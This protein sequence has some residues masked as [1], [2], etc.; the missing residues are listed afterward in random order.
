M[1][2]LLLFTVLSTAAVAG[3][4]AD[5]HLLAGARRFREGRFAE[6]L[7]EFRVAQ[8]LGHGGEAGWYSAACLV[9]L[10]RP[11]DALEAFAEAE[12]RSP[13]T[14]DELFDYY[15]AIACHDARLYLCADRLLRGVGDRAGPRIR[16]EARRLR[17]EVAAIL[18]P[19]PARTAIDWYQK[20]ARQAAQGGRPLIAKAYSDEAA[21]LSARRTDRYVGD[22]G[23]GSLARTRQEV[24]A[25]AK[26]NR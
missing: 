24:P 20:Q 12:Q 13:R 1:R 25:R 7:V 22:D 8:K 17:A 15:R 4:G 6:A 2:A 19:E 5:E 10:N 18:R 16:D 3:A 11:D 21:G 9:R 23:S 26:G 14:R